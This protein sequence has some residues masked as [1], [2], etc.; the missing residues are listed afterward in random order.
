[1]IYYS[2]QFCKQFAS[3][4]GKVRPDDAA[5]MWVAALVEEFLRLEAGEQTGN[6]GFGGNHH[7]ADG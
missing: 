5:I 3:L 7:A 6:V 4:R 2:I 1:L